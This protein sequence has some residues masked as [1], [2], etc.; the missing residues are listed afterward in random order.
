[1]KIAIGADHAGFVL[2]ERLTEKLI[3][4]GHQVVDYG[5]HSTESCDYPDYAAPVARD[6]ATGRFDCGILVCHTGIG[7]CIAA[8]KVRG[9]RAALGTCVDEVRLIR[10]HNDANILTLGAGFVQ[11][12]E[13]EAMVDV[14][15]TT[16][17][18]NGRHARRI[19]KI[20]AMEEASTEA[21]E[22]AKA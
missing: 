5:T 10:D 17:F 3:Q 21:Q 1:M 6:V 2:K 9:I 18:C 22:G 11:P 14:F 13:A 15:L 12:E 7:M 16:G 20:A 4:E 19:A 8:N